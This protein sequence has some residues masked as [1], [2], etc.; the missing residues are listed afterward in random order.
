MDDALSQ[1]PQ[2]ITRH[3]EEVVIIIAY[4]QFRKMTFSEQ[5]L[6]DFF[7]NSP[8]V[9][10]DLDLTRDKSALREEMVL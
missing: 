7:R 6:S 10:E 2:I 9:G 8:L 1:G 3:G 5:K 4:D